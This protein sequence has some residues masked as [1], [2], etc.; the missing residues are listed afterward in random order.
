[1]RNRKGFT[2]VEMLVVL[3]IIATLAGVLTGVI[4]HARNLSIRVQCQQNLNQIGQAVSLLVLSNNGLFPIGPPSSAIAPLSN[5]YPVP[6]T[7]DSNP[8]IP[9]NSGFP[10]WAR[11]FELSKGDMGGSSSRTPLETI[12]KTS[13]PR[14]PTS[15][16]T[17]MC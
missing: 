17:A 11:V 5:A 6:Q 12:A 7:S 16:R 3:A 14:I 8:S 2:L 4:L 9:N 13:L 10:W 15:T 1:M